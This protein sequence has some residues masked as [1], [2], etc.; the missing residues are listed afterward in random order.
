[1]CLCK[2]FTIGLYKE[3]ICLYIVNM[4]LYVMPVNNNCMC[5]YM[6]SILVN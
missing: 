2:G 1:M 3:S 5:C 4:P 6:Q